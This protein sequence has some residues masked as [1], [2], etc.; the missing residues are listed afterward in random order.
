MEKPQELE[1]KNGVI[2]RD[3]KPQ[4]FT[5]K[6]SI[7]DLS[8]VL[9][10]TAPHSP[11]HKKSSEN[12]QNTLEKEKPLDFPKKIKSKTPPAVSSE[13]ISDTKETSK[14]LTNSLEK[15]HRKAN[16]FEKLFENVKKERVTKA[17]V[18]NDKS[19][20]KKRKNQSH[21]QI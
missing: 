18:N 5:H 1:G 21:K 9:P 13:K 7:P 11:T 17:L 6:R 12:Q 20:T 3:K 2:E 8:K 4:K 16:P 14:S 15:E 10:S 19:E